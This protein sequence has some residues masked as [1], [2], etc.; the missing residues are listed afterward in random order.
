MLPMIIR[1]ASSERDQHRIKVK[2]NSGKIYVANH[3]NIY[4][5]FPF[6][7]LNG[8]YEIK[9]IMIESSLFIGTVS[10]LEVF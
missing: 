7:P 2:E 9:T 4:L 1:R 5:S 6:V 3:L 8:V 10:A